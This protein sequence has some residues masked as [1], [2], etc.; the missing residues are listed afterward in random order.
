MDG[1]TVYTEYTLIKRSVFRIAFAEA[2]FGTNGLT[3]LRR[4]V[5]CEC[6]IVLIDGYMDVKLEGNRKVIQETRNMVLAILKPRQF[7]AQFELFPM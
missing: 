2:C 3:L 6:M 5:Q 4:Y 7:S 1:L